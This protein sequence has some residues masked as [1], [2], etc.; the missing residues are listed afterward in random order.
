MNDIVANEESIGLIWE[1]GEETLTG[2]LIFS[3]SIAGVVLNAL[4]KELSAS[5]RL[6]EHDAIAILFAGKRFGTGYTSAINS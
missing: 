2:G 6:S 3:Y 1:Y 5:N 4:S